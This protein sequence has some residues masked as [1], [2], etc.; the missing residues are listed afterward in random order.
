MTSRDYRRRLP[1]T[2]CTHDPSL[3]HFAAGVMQVN[4]M[5]P[6]PIMPSHTPR[7]AAQVVIAILNWNGYALT[8]ACV[9]S[10]ARLSGSNHRILIVDNG[11]VELEGERLAEELGD[12]VQALTLP[13]NLGVGGGYNA[14]IRWARERGAE[15]VLLLNNDTI[16]DDPLLVRRLVDASGPD[17][18]AVGPL[19]KEIGG[20]V[21]SAG[22]VLDW[23][24]YVTG[25]LQANEIVSPASPYPVAWIDGSCMLVSVRAAYE[26]QG[27]DEIFFLYWEEVDVCVRAWR[28]G[29]RCL[30][31]P[32]ASIVHL[33]GQTARPSQVDH[34]MLRNSILFM[35]RH[36]TLGQ[37]ADFLLRQIFWRMPVFLARRVKNRGG[38]RQSV[39]MVLRSLAWNFRDA[40]KVRAWRQM[41]G[42]SLT[43][44]QPAEST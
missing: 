12:N 16:V 28:H 1:V 39:G 29:L 15:Y 11:S 3:V 22:G 38:V 42:G 35:R 36:G 7:Q 32:R 20:R 37:N 43:E 4:L 31:E 19:I 34:L 9:E 10:L 14:G 13:R 17:V 33:V 18:F 5:S 25:H 26:I 21:W 23:S 6:R 44:A 40:A 27:F 2:D 30:V 41:A 24:T 8:R